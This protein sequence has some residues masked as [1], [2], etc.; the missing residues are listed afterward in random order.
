MRFTAAMPARWAQKR[1]KPLSGQNMASAPSKSG[2]WHYSLPR[3]SR[4][5]SDETFLW[6]CQHR[7]LIAMSSNLHAIYQYRHIPG[8]LLPSS[9]I[10]SVQTISRR[11][12][13]GDALFLQF[14]RLSRIFQYGGV[15]PGIR[16]ILMVP[17]FHLQEQHSGVCRDKPSLTQSARRPLASRQSL[18]PVI[19]KEKASSEG[20]LPQRRFAPGDPKRQYRR[21]SAQI[22]IS[23]DLV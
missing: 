22:I 10:Q 6:P 14:T 16:K 5:I 15:K 11:K 13:L 12:P 19:P 20:A 21:C 8:R 18:I 23:Q 3:D 2:A 9:A 7:S 1:F 4:A 17:R